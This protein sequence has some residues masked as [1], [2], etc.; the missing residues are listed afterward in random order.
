VKKPCVPTLTNASEACCA[1][2]RRAGDEARAVRVAQQGRTLGSEG[3]A[4]ERIMPPAAM[5]A[6]MMTP[7]WWCDEVTQG[8][9]R[10]WKKSEGKDG[11]MKRK[12]PRTVCTL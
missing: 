2:V 1:R 12:L 8:E 11:V 5:S 10:G 4:R 6:L 3:V 9:G 7:V